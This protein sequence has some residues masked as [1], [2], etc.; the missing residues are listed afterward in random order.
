MSRYSKGLENGQ[1]LAWGYDRPLSEYFIQLEGFDDETV[2]EIG[3]YYT[4]KPHP[5]YPTKLTYTNS[6][7]LEIFNQYAHVIPEAHLSAIASDL[8]F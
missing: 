1:T 6:E 5:E 2:F 3:S 8:P 4:T 7:L